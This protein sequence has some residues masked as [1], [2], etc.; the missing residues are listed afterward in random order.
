VSLGFAWGLLGLLAIPVL[1]WMERR[2]RRPRHLVWPSLLLWRGLPEEAAAR[3]RRFQPLLLLECLAAG[4]LA[5]A[6]SEPGLSA[7]GARRVTV[8]LDIAPPML[9]TRADG[10]TALEAT[11]D[12]VQR[13]RA[14]LGTGDEVT[15]VETAGDLRAVAAGLDPEVLRVVASARAGVDGPGWLCIGRAPQGDNVGI[16][17]VE[18][19]ADRLGFA[20]ACDGGARS[21]RVRIGTEERSVGTGTWVEAPR[22]D[23]IEILEPDNYAADDRVTLRPLGLTARDETGSARVRA[24]LFAAGLPAREATEADLVV[25]PAVGADLPGPVDGADCVAEAGPF[26]GLL[27]DDC[28]WG[29]ATAIAEP[30][31]PLLRRGDAVLAGWAT[32]EPGVLVLGLPVDREWDAHGT[33][34]V[35]VERAKRARADALL[36]PGEV[37]LLDLVVAPPPGFVPTRGV[38]RPWDGRLPDRPAAGAGRGIALARPL[39]GAAALVLL[40]YL[41]LR[42]RGGSLGDSRSRGIVARP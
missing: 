29:H 2:R 4:L 9:A 34:A 23:R 39:A 17:A 30:V 26:E 3:R 15:V 40:L 24:A 12:E 5:L 35:L 16:D 14:A 37:R 41:V 28:T 11:R 32:D 33:L 25:R 22:V 20:L 1:I 36:A 21:V 7:G 6:A 8:V 19:E 10:R 18:V 42:V 31:T 27:L 13:V 38:D